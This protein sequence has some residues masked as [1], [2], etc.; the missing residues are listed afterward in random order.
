MKLILCVLLL[1]VLGFLASI[2]S[3]RK[4]HLK[5][6]VIDTKSHPQLSWS[7]RQ[8][9]FQ[10]LHQKFEKL[11]DNERGAHYKDVL[12]ALDRLTIHAQPLVIV[13]IKL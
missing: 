5:A 12:S 11:L 13:E 10:N 7:Q 8:T 1:Y 9:M 2:I 6:G 4:I 3:A